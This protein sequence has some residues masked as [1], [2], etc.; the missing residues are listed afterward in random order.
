MYWV[1]DNG[2]RGPNIDATCSIWYEASAAVALQCAC[3]ASRCLCMQVKLIAPMSV[4]AGSGA[5]LR[6]ALTVCSHHPPTTTSAFQLLLVS[7]RNAPLLSS[8]R[9]TKNQELCSSSGPR[10]GGPRSDQF[11]KLE[12]RLGLRDLSRPRR[13]R[14]W[15]ATKP[16]ASRPDLH[17]SGASIATVCPSVCSRLAEFCKLFASC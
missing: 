7:S 15:H 10:I 12:R 4:T 1:N 17:L 14:C 16:V 9:G 8:R 6:N 11:P 2:V 3:G 5:A 13:E